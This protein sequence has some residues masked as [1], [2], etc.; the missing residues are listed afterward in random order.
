MWI[1]RDLW[2][3]MPDQDTPGAAALR[4]LVG[5]E[6]ILSWS[7]VTPTRGSRRIERNNLVIEDSIQLASL[8]V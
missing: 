1:K 8:E 3:E 6:N 4:K 7:I 2:S 5:S